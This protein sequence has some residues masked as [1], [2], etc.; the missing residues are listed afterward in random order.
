[1]KKLMLG[2]VLGSNLVFA[3][4]GEAPANWGDFHFGLVNDGN[5]IYNERLMAGNAMGAKVEYRYIYIN[6]GANNGCDPTQTQLSTAFSPWHD[7]VAESEQTGV[8]PAYVIYLLQEDAGSWKL[9]ES[10]NDPSF[11]KNFF[12]HLKTVAE[13]SAGKKPIFIVEPDTW[14]YLVQDNIDPTTAPALVNNVDPLTYPFLADLPNTYSGLAKAMVRILKHY[15]P[16]SY[17]GFLMA[18]WAPW[19]GNDAR[20]MVYWTPAAIEQSASQI[21][22]MYNKLVGPPGGPDRGDFLGVE[23]NGHSAGYWLYA[24][25]QKTDKWYWQDQQHQNWLSWA[26]SMAQKVDLPLLGWQISIG[27]MGLSN[28]CLTGPLGASTGGPAATGNC[29]FEDTFFPY[30]FAHTKDFMDAG[31]IGMMVGKGL[32]DDTDYGTQAGEGDGGWFFEQLVQFNLG[33]PYVTKMSTP[34]L[35]KDYSM[36]QGQILEVSPQKLTFSF[37]K[38]AQGNYHIRNIEGQVLQSFPAQ[39]TNVEI[40]LKELTA[41]QY[42]LEGDRTWA[43][44]TLP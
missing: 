5:K 44:F 26:K 17:A 27:H 38:A 12:Y 10:T 11:M 37:P 16:D 23:K 34:T 6:N 3:K 21:S 2:L 19:S 15:A 42:L 33:R 29:A 7:Y 31:F 41:G 25:A 43:K 39:K 24:N 30:F 35:R 28:Q 20:G 8:R 4:W 18:T 36:L 22:D 14:G 1:M 9:A 40:P 13:K 32:A